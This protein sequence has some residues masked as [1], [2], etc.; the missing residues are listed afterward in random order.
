MMT[1]IDHASPLH[2]SGSQTS[3]PTEPRLR[4]NQHA[5]SFTH[6]TARAVI[7]RNRIQV[8]HQGSASMHIQRLQPET[9]CEQRNL[10]PIYLPQQFLVHGL[11]QLVRGCRF[12]LYLLSVQGRCYIRTTSR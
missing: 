5:V 1:R 8:L 11:A 3:Q 10:R 12:R 4:V 7:Y 6:G 9:N 2:L